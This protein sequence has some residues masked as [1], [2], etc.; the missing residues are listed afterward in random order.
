MPNS[1]SPSERQD[2]CDPFVSAT[3]RAC[4]EVR[5]VEEPQGL[6][7]PEH[8]GG[9]LLD[10]SRRDVNYGRHDDLRRHQLRTG[11]LR[12]PCGDGDGVS[13]LSLSRSS[14]TACLSLTMIMT[15]EPCVCGRLWCP[16]LTSAT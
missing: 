5:E 2:H 11:R 9:C 3:H 10:R 16:G 14:L 8:I 12:S 1:V 6:R 13:L 4:C 7:Y 15:T